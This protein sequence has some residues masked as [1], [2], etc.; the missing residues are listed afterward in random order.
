MS[1]HPPPPFDDE[2][3]SVLPEIRKLL[4][5]TITPAHILALREENLNAATIDEVIAGR[6]IEHRTYLTPGHNGAP[7][8]AL[9]VFAKTRRTRLR[10]AI[11][12]IHGGGMFM[13][14][15]FSGAPQYLN[16]V[17]ELDVAV[18]S[19]EYR[20]SPENP[21]PAPHEDC[22][23]GLLW[24]FRNAEKLGLDSDRIVIAGASAG[25]GLAAA[26]ALKLRDSHEHQ[27]RGQM[28]I[29]PMLDD[30]NETVSSQQID[31]IGVWDRTSNE[32]GWT[33][34]LGARR[35]GKDVNAY[36]A[37]GRAVDLARLPP[38][39]IDVGSADVFRDEAVSYARRMWEQGGV[40]ELHVW[41][42][43][44]HGFDV[45]VPNAQL[46][47]NAFAARKSWLRRILDG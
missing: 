38:T 12:F 37:P 17:D 31:G 2:L 10:P 18:I 41:P 45:F 8:I 16:W 4:P 34:L 27:L 39:F 14:D 33:A 19:V 47:R 7:S 23:S 22:L 44:F 26:V 6:P 20:L 9:S 3:H 15:R 21:D 40:A 43:G 13:G 11:Y 46:S 24:T 30:R 28:L 35:G 32:T 5:V 29:Y 42:G 36:S 1:I 25:G